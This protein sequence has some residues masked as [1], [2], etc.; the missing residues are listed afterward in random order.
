MIIVGFMGPAY[1]IRWTKEKDFR[2]LVLAGT[3]TLLGATIGVMGNAVATLTTYDYA[4]ASIR[5]GSELATTGGTLTSKGLS[6]DYAFTYSTYKTE[7]FELL[8]PKIYGGGNNRTEFNEG[9]LKSVDALQSMP[10]QLGQQLQHLLHIYWG[11]IS[12]DTG[13]PA[14][15]GAVICLLA[16]IGLFILDGKHK[17][18]ILAACV[19]SLMMSWG[20]NLQGFN[21][22]L[23]KVL[24]GYNK[25]RAPSVI[26]VIPN[27]LFC[28]LAILSLQRLLT[29]TA[30]EKETFWG[31]YK[32]ALYFTGGVFA[33]LFILYF[34]FDY[35]TAADKDALQRASGLQQPQITDY[36]KGFLTALKEDRQA[37]FLG[38]LLRSLFYTATAAALPDP[39]RQSQN[40]TTADHRHRRRTRLYRPDGDERPVPQLRQLPGRRRGA[41]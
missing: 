19:I 38:S 21:G 10:P 26:L 36:V 12:A 23:L 24:P 11:D 29:L 41:K 27:F 32:K 34:S 9:N 6:E 8:V 35:T 28:V 20:S 16:F 30:S 1:I 18:W 13:G 17:W 22:F 15:A 2:R 4:P 39:R 40:Q 5:G 7:S 31:K 33:L 3:L 25:F 14:Y 37:V